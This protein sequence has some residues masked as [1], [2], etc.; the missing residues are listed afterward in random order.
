VACSNSFVDYLEFNQARMDA[1]NV[2]YG[3]GLLGGVAARNKIFNPSLQPP[4]QVVRQTD[5]NFRAAIATL[6]P[7][8]RLAENLARLDQIEAQWQKVQDVRLRVLTLAEAGNTEEAANILAREENPAWRAIR[9]ELQ[10]L[11][12]AERESTLQTRDQV[13]GQVARTFTS[14][15]LV[16]TIAVIVALGLSLLIV[17]TVVRRISRTKSMIDDLAAGE[18]NLTRR[19]AL[20]GKDELANMADSFNRFVEKVHTL[21]SEVAGSTAQVAAAA[22]ELAAV[23]QESNNAVQR[24]HSETDQVAT[25]MN[26]MT[27]TVQDVARNALGDADAA[28][29]ADREAEGG[30]QE[31][32]GT[33][34]SIQRLAK[35]VERA[36]E[37][38]EAVG[39]DSE[40]IGSVLDVIKGIAEQTK[41]LALNTAIEAA[42]AGEQGCGF[43]VVADEVRTL[44]S[45]TQKSTEEIQNMIERLQSG[46]RKAV[47]VM[48]EGR[49]QASESV[50]SAGD[51]QQ[52][53]GRITAAVGTIRDMNTQIA[54]AAEQ[55]SAVAEEINKNVINISDI[56]AQVSSG[57]EQ[58]RTAGEELARLAGQLQRLV[59]QFRV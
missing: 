5:E 6:R 4:A 51:A 58:T 25:A 18:G 22:E 59:G 45:R 54:S 31:V 7:N 27:A 17:T 43:A 44:A 24:Q 2:M 32:S 37:A 33:M 8:M 16:G 14:G 50:E 49:G 11:M 47:E 53:L 36:A 21:V 15:L 52:A 29:Q 30:A 23:T 40:Q 9:I 41:L 12:D 28:Q 1:L 35:E 34:G 56:G 55:Q 10:V 20:G 48:R 38:M 57:A 19:L 46:T 13:Q 3:D 26:E 42:R 39:K